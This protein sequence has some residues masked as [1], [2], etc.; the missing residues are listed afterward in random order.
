MGNP[1]TVVAERFLLTD[2]NGTVRA[3]LGVNEQGEVMFGL[4]D[5]RGNIRAD[6]SVTADGLPRVE[7]CDSAGNTRALMCVDEQD[8]PAITLF[9]SGLVRLALSVNADGPFVALTDE[10]S[11]RQVTLLASGDTAL[12]IFQDPDGRATVAAGI[13]ADQTAGF[14]VAGPGVTSRIQLALRGDGTAD[15]VVSDPAGTITTVP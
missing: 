1:T 11:R 15:L 7:L 14:S 8:A 9:D 2:S 4:S 3:V 12:A 5:A 13:G 10:Q 6:V